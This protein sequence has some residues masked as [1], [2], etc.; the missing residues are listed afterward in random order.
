MKRSV[1]V[2]YKKY[3][4]PSENKGL[5]LAGNGG[6]EVDEPPEQDSCSV[7]S[8]SYLAASLYNYYVWLTSSK[9]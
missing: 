5:G 4:Q 7:R 2:Q 1:V 9:L 6:R 8:C 3:K